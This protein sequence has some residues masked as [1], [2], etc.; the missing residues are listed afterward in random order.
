[1]KK[2]LEC[3]GA[4]ETETSASTYDIDHGKMNIPVLSRV[5]LKRIIQVRM[6]VSHINRATV[7]IAFLIRKIEGHFG[8]N[9]DAL[10]Y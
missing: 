5:K 9:I 4:L 10:Y 6:V 3:R 2:H 8:H 7:K 1:M